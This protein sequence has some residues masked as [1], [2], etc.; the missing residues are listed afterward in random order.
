MQEDL[1]V[2]GLA[3]G[4]VGSLVTIIS[5]MRSVSSDVKRDTDKKIDNAHRD[6]EN[7][8]RGFDIR[9]DRIDTAM[10]TLMSKE[11]C[12]LISGHI[13]SELSEIKSQTEMVQKIITM[14]NNDLIEQ[15]KDIKILI[16]KLTQD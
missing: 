9:A 3:L 4:F 12:G 10:N 15:R 13:R 16:E 2:L 7:V 1:T 5:F 6:F 14:M 11:M 8:K